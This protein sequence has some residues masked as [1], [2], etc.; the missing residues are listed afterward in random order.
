MES[1]HLGS[2]LHNCYASWTI[3]A[4]KPYIKVCYIYIDKK[5]KNTCKLKS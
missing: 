1:G 5:L 2:K 4:I 3:S